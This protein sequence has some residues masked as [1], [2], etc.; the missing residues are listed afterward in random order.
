M[1]NDKVLALLEKVPNS[2]DINIYLQ[3]CAKKDSISD[4][5]IFDSIVLKYR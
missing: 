4:G 2:V 3:V 5:A 1:S